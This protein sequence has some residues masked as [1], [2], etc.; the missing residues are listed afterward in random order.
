M[1]LLDRSAGEFFDLRRLGFDD[2]MLARMERFSHQHAARH[3]PGDRSPRAAANRPLCTFPRLKRI[4]SCRT[5]KI[6]TIEDPG[7]IPDGWDQPDPREPADR[8]HVRVRPAATSCARI[9]RHHGGAKF[10]D[11]E[12]AGHRDSCGA[13]RAI[14]CSA[15]CTHHDAP[16]AVTRLVDYG[17]GELPDYVVPGGGAGAAAGAG[18]LAAFCKQPNGNRDVA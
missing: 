1:R 11:R 3:L 12:T 17:G 4:N 9:G 14:W 18:D 10:R 13:L 7:G 15:R 5:T 8:A 16:S 2:H 6:I